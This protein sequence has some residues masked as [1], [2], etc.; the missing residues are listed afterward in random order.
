MTTLCLLVTRDPSFLER[1]SSAFASHTPH[2]T[3]PIPPSCASDFFSLDLPINLNNSFDLSPTSQQRVKR[4]FSP[5]TNSNITASRSRQRRLSFD[6]VLHFS[7]AQPLSAA[8]L[9]RFA[10]I[11]KDQKELYRKHH[12]PLLFLRHSIKRLEFSTSFIMTTTMVSTCTREAVAALSGELSVGLFEKYTELNGI[13]SRHEP[14]LRSRMLKKKKS[15][16]LRKFLKRV[17][18]EMPTSHRPDVTLAYSAGEDMLEEMIELHRTS[19]LCP[20]INQDDLVK[21]SN[22]LLFLNSRA[23]NPPYAFLQEDY[24]RSAMAHTSLD[25]VNNVPTHIMAFQNLDTPSTYGEVMLRPE[26]TQLTPGR[27]QYSTS[28]GMVILESQCCMTEL[29]LKIVR[30]LLDDISHN[31]LLGPLFPILDEPSSLLPENYC[32]FLA[33]SEAPYLLPATFNIAELHS[34]AQATVASRKEDIMAMR[35]GPRYFEENLYEW[36]EH[37]PEMVARLGFRTSLDIDRPR[38][39]GKALDSFISVENSTWRLWSLIEEL[40]SADALLK[41]EPKTQR[42]SMSSGPLSVEDTKFLNT[43]HDKI[44]FVHFVFCSPP[45]REYMRRRRDGKADWIPG[46]TP[47]ADREITLWALIELGKDDGFEK[48]NNF[49]DLLVRATDNPKQNKFLSP[50]VVGLIYDL[51]LVSH[52]LDGLKRYVPGIASRFKYMDEDK[53]RV[54]GVTTALNKLALS[55]ECVELGTPTK[56]KF[57]YPKTNKRKTKANNE[58]MIKSEHNLEKFWE[59]ADQ[60]IYPNIF[61]HSGREMAD[62][63]KNALQPEERFRTDPWVSAVRIDPIRQNLGVDPAKDTTS[64]LFRVLSIDSSHSAE[65]VPQKRSKK[66]TQGKAD[67]SKAPTPPP[68]EEDFLEEEPEPIIYTDARSLEVFQAMF[69]TP[70]KRAQAGEIAWSDVLHAMTTIGFTAE[71]GDGSARMFKPRDVN[72]EGVVHPI[73]FHAPHP[74]PKLRRLWARRAGTQLT[75]QYGWHWGMFKLRE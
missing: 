31:E 61:N 38:G 30:G 47:D 22:F 70:K 12:K 75:R 14:T 16:T 72:I 34:V 51:Q 53:L 60:E 2:V 44:A 41:D 54:G 25:N 28:Q 46:I 43:Y 24:E 48:S 56:G 64:A 57:T 9:L 73:T 10:D 6:I 50:F 59:Q 1:A 67:P 63:F 17:C 55:A 37:R 3:V 21:D 71:Q 68:P 42:L 66:K 58:A 27:R 7:I 39:W 49:V 5:A 36:K 40:T 15:K 74:S 69:F 45:L 19:F 29:L 52:C 18:P 23:R 11:P 32:P 13:V 4:L 35:D 33:T 20:H 26:S 8:F 65:P 62:L